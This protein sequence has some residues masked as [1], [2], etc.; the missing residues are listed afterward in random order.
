MTDVIVL[1]SPEVGFVSGVVVL[2]LTLAKGLEFDAVLVADVSESSYGGDHNR[3]LLYTAATRAIH[4]RWL[5]ALGPV[6]P[7]MPRMVQECASD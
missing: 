2:P 1:D 5:M 3:L 4:R 6:V 7:W